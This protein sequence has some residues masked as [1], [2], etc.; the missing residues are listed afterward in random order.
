M[1]ESRWLRRAGPGI[2]AVG[3]LAVIASTTF[4]AGSPDWDPPRCEGPVRVA[5]ATIGAWYQIEP[6]LTDGERRGQ[7]LTLGQAG[8]GRREQLRLDAESLESGPRGGTVHR[9]TDV[10]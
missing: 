5:A 2:A 10:R 6:V 4:G 9:G 7:R 1:V 3:A 8:G